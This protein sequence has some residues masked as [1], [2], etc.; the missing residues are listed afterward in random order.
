M[1][2]VLSVFWQ[3]FGLFDQNK[4]SKNVLDDLEPGQI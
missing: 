1:H 2:D 3:H 4:E